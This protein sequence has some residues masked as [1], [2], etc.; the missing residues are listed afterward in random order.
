ML[1]NPLGVG[2]GLGGGEKEPRVV[3]GRVVRR[4]ALDPS[5]TGMWR[6]K[7]AVEMEPTQGDLASVFEEL[8]SRQ[9]E[10]FGRD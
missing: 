8:S 3:S 5:E 10:I 6:E 4:E 9:K 7:V 2:A 1:E